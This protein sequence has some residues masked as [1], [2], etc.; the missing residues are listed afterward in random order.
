VSLLV[1]VI[2][3]VVSAGA[4]VAV[5]MGGRWRRRTPGQHPIP[6]V[7]W[8]AWSPGAAPDATTSSPDLRPARRDHE[9]SAVSVTAGAKLGSGGQGQIYEIVGDPDRVLKAFLVPIPAAK[10]NLDAVLGALDRV[11]ENLR[12]LP[13]TLCWPERAV[14]K[15]NYLLGYVMRRIQSPFYFTSSRGLLSKRLL[16]EL[17][18]AVPR[19]SAFE[20]PVVKPN[21]I[22]ELVRLV[23]RFLDAM[24]RQD[25][26]YGDIS[27]TNFT[28]ALDPI[29][30]CVHDFDSTRCLG[31]DAFTA[32][33]PLDTIDW[34]DPDAR[35]ASVATLDSDRYKFALLAYRM[36]IA[37]DLHSRLD[38]GGAVAAAASE[39]LPSSDL[40]HL[41]RRAAGP[42]GTRPQL[43]EWLR[44]L[45]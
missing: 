4:A 32:Q 22:L 40:Q 25:L 26:V 35:D 41:W 34:D 38:P 10:D 28:F 29:R 45:A 9:A 21:E 16:R 31:G 27:W 30:L 14:T 33:P 15:E 13:I 17:Q 23:A 8:T 2:L 43:V 6:P 24:H 3:V 1:A 36:L 5:L 19:R 37:K 39:V 20:M 12:S 42:L 7:G 11:A 44:A 18:Y